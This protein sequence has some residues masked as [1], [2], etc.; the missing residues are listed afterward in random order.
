GPGW[1]SDLARRVWSS[2]VRLAWVKVRSTPRLAAP[3]ALTVAY[4]PRATESTK[5]RSK[6][7]RT[8]STTL[9]LR[10]AAP[11]APLFHGKR[12]GQARGSGKTPNL[13]V[14]EHPER[15]RTPPDSTGR[16]TP[17]RPDRPAV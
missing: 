5:S 12:N 1:A 15:T 7:A 4:V 11:A 14:G 3:I 16:P 10:H 8:A 9:L 17:R 2:T 13:P 6:T